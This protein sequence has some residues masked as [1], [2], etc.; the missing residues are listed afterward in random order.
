VEENGQ[1][2]FQ[3]TWD[4]EKARYNLR[5]H[6]VSF[7]EAATVFLDPLARTIPDLD[8]SEGEIRYLTIGLS[9]QGHLLVV[10]YT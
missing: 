2:S 7:D 8:H 6:R 10:S 1:P 9:L 5:E 3:F 4:E